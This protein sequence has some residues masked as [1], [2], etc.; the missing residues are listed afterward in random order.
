MLSG[1]SPRN[2]LPKGWTKHIRNVFEA[3]KRKSHH[4]RF[5]ERI[6]PTTFAEIVVPTTRLRKAS[7]RPTLAESSGL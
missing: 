6:L 1:K 5:A 7:F 2:P 3:W 4:R